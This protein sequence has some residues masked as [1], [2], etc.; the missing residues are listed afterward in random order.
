MEQ[1]LQFFIYIPVLGFIVSVLQNRKNEKALSAIA[2]GTTAIQLLYLAWFV[3]KWW[4]LKFPVLDIK[5]FTILKTPQFDFYIDFFFD[6]ST[7]VF[8]AV[9]FIL[10]LLVSVFSKYY[11]HREDGFKRYFN[12][13]QLFFLG[14]NIVVVAGNFETLFVGWEMVGIT[15]FLLISFYRDRYLPVKNA[16]KVISMYRLG[17]IFLILSMWLSHHLWHSNISFFH[18]QDTGVMLSKI[19][20]DIVLA[21][22]IGLSI[23]IAAAVKSAIFPFSSWVS[24]AMEGP[25]SSSA[26]FYGSLS[27]HLGV[28]LLLRTYAFWEHLIIVKVLILIFGALTSLIC[29]SIAAAQPTAKTQIAYSSITQIGLIFIE[30]ALG[31]H[32]IA[33]IHFAGN[34][35]LRAYQILVSPS[36]L[37]YLIHNQLFNFSPRKDRKPN[38]LINSLYI[39]SIKEYNMDMSHFKFLWKPFKKLGAIF[40]LLNN[41]VAY[42][43]IVG[44]FALGIYVDINENDMNELLIDSLVVIYAILSLALILSSF[45]ERGSGKKAWNKVIAGHLFIILSISLDNHIPFRYLFLYLSGIIFFGLLGY[46]SLVKLEKAEKNID[47][48]QYHG[49]GYEYPTIAVVFLIACLGLIG[50]PISP[51]Y[52]GIDLLLTYI[53]KHQYFLIAFSALSILFI[54]LSVLRIY[55]RLFCGQHKKAYHPIAFKSS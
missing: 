13:I 2:I 12:N 1:Y 37:S 43:L 55:T 14:Y 35:F 40:S 46:F 3:Y 8:L 15:S 4:L 24:R 48:D 29:N 30:V 36:V 47:L 50:F 10:A 49:N 17:D 34:A 18:F 32:T 31:F 26:I 38:K 9:G 39:L 16:M 19:N 23:F 5:Q 22:I 27:I 52:I 53:E 7:A 54:E 51:L 44:L 6:H 41:R 45:S 28:F 21:T 20:G 11:I 33:L 42:I 25:S